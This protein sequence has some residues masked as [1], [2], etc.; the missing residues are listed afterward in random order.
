MKSTY[1]TWLRFFNEGKASQPDFVVDAFLAYLLSWDL[2]SSDPED[3]LKLYIFPLSI[4]IT[5]GAQFA[6]AP[7]YL[8]SQHESID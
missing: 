3:G 7:L 1:S 2:L 4:L 5:K 8:G 6:L